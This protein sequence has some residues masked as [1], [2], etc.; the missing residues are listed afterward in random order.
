MAITLENLAT[1]KSSAPPRSTYQHDFRMEYLFSYRVAWENPPE[2]LGPVPEGL[3]V[4]FYLVGGEVEGPRLNGRIKPVGGEWFV[5]RPD[6][7]GMLD[8]RATIETDDGALIYAPFTGI[9][10]IGEGGYEALLRGELAPDGTTFRS[11]PRYSTAHPD[12]QWIN[13]LQCMGIGEVHP[14]LGEA[15]VDVYAVR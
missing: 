3:R 15:R 7:V 13:R 9:L 6:G 8:M 5:V 1:L 2:I 4:N 11:A 12:Y 14:S 10:D